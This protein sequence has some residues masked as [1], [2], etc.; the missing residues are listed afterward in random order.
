MF[1]IESQKIRR[2]EAILERAAHGMGSGWSTSDEAMSNR[3]R[4]VT[5]VN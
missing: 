5:G 4:D 1:K 3:A 2:M